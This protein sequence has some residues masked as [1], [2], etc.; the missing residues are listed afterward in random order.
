MRRAAVLMC[1]TTLILSLPP[2]YE[3]VSL[4][5]SEGSRLPVHQA[6]FESLGLPV[7]IKAMAACNMRTV[8]KQADTNGCCALH[9]RSTPEA[10]CG[11]VVELCAS[12]TVRIVCS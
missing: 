1:S 11:R 5:K 4:S 12:G 7:T 3:E 9:R 8:T 2:P 6:I 10:A